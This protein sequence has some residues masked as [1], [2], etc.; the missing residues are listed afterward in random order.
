M[1]YIEAVEPKAKKEYNL[2][3]KNWQ[4][5]CSW[6]LQW[7]WQANVKMKV[8]GVTWATALLYLCEG[9]VERQI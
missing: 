9:V 2:Q 7:R 1:S 6:R 5:L 8:E 3:K 4:V